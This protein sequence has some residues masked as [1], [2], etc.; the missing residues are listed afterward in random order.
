MEA[1]LARC[2]E[3]RNGRTAE[4]EVKDTQLG[5]GREGGVQ[6]GVEADGAA[7][8]GGEVVG[9]RWCWCWCW[10]WCWDVALAEGSEGAGRRLERRLQRQDEERGEGRLADAALSAEDQDEVADVGEPGGDR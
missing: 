10:C 9:R 1:V 6:V 7:D 8:D 5:R 3:A 4:V 2:K